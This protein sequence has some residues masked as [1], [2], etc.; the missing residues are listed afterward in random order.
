MVSPGVRRI[1]NSEQGSSMI[2]VLLVLF[3]LIAL[4]AAGLSGA[5]SNLKLANNYQ[6]GLQA[7]QAAEAGVV[8]AVKVMN[9]ATPTRLDLDVYDHWSTLFGTAPVPLSGA[10]GT[11]YTV[12]PTSPDPYRG[13]VKDTLMI[14]AVGHGPGQ[15]QRT[16]V[17][18]VGM[19]PCGAIDMPSSGIST[20]F[21]GNHFL[22]DGNDYLMGCTP[23]PSLGV[24]CINPSGTPVLGIS[25]REP[26]DASNIIGS[27]SSGQY[28]NVVGAD[29]GGAAASVGSCSG[30]S[31][32]QIQNTFVPRMLASVPPASIAVNPQLNGNDTFGSVAVPRVTHFTGDV[33]I[34]GTVSGAGILIVD[35]GLTVSGNMNF[36]GLVIVTGTTQ[37]TNVQGNS[38]ILGGVWTTSL[39]L[40]VSGSAS[41]SYSSQALD[42]VNNLAAQQNLVPKHVSV[43]AWSQG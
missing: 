31:S 30:A 10:A 24:T 23:D 14:T 42:L 3:A 15:S 38:T 13:S 1:A 34:N 40:N 33:T 9:D 12:T 16:I 37:F 35:G 2:L 7:M 36:T 11:S 41:V 18:H 26:S 43:V 8:H 27:L 28:D 21:N 19:N 39:T 29:A 6:T 25:T 32:A 4:G 22:V 5:G 20:T 17:A